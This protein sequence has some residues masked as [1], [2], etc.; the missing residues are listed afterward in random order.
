MQEILT[1][2]G[3]LT[4]FENNIIV[5]KRLPKWREAENGLKKTDLPQNKAT[6]VVNVENEDIST[7]IIGTPDVVMSND[8]NHSIDIDSN[9]NASTKWLPLYEIADGVNFDDLAV[10]GAKDLTRMI[11]EN[12][13][14][15]VIGGYGSFG[16]TQSVNL[17]GRGD[18]EASQKKSNNSFINLIKQSFNEFIDIVLARSERN[19][20]VMFDALKFFSI[21][22]LTS[23]A[24]V[25]TYRD[26]V[27]DYL[28]ALHNAVTAGQ[29][30]LME[31]LLRGLITNKYES[32]LYTEG[33]YY[34]V[35]EEQIVSFI[36]Q[37]EKG[38][39]LDYIKNFNR[40]LPQNVVNKISKINDLEIFDNY[41]V[42][43]YDP[44]G[45]VYKETAR[46]EAKRKD[47]ILFGLIAGSNKLYY[48]TDWVD[49]YCDLTLEKF[50]DTIGVKKEELHMDYKPGKEM[51]QDKTEKPKRKYRKRKKNKENKENKENKSK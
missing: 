33:L 37:C 9:V 2:E 7:Y 18:S 43:Y 26:R 11:A 13:L 24:S 10:A 50:I 34:I 30:A 36:K 17:I 4:I 8:S 25:N 29:T 32:V 1:K 23:K 20:E 35:T 49:E 16:N 28:K 19:N 21:V 27:N 47:P 5:D 44:E 15:F 51:P 12:K 45:K 39:K 3:K 31:D 22:K 38:L 6:R 48:I 46:E 40:P 14:K 41:V 42:L